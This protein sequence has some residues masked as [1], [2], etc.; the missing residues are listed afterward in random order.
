YLGQRFAIEQGA[1]FGHAEGRASNNYVR[2]RGAVS[3]IPND[4][5]VVKVVVS[6]QSPA[7]DDDPVRS[8]EYFEQVNLP[9]SYEHYLHTEVGATRFLHAAQKVS[10]G[11][12]QDLS[13][14]RAMF[15]T[16]SDG[17]HGL[18]ILDSKDLPSQGVRF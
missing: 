8:R 1:Q 10:M 6:T 2:P 7:Q 11:V 18:L 15:L 14:H 17:R 12:F 4:K 3:W 9:P 16:A 13:T 5:T